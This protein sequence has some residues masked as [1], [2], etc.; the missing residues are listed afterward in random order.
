MS[1]RFHYLPRF[2]HSEVQQ[3][4]HI[5]FQFLFLPNISSPVY[6]TSKM[7]PPSVY[8]PDQYSFLH[9][10][11]PI[12]QYVLCTLPQNVSQV[13]PHLSIATVPTLVYAT[14]SILLTCFSA[15]TLAPT[16]NAL[17]RAR[18]LQV[19]MPHPFFLSN[20]KLILFHEARDPIKRLN[21]SAS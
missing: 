21:L 7:T 8:Q 18:V 15:S 17:Y 3:V 5:F 14:V 9:S 4:S 12:Y 1:S 2:L 13:C 19:S 16:N 11:Y 10:S 20:E 6:P